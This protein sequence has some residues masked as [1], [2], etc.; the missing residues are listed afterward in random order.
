MLVVSE[1]G[2]D[3][4]FLL[5]L[6]GSMAGSSACWKV[7][8]KFVL[9]WACHVGKE[10]GQEGAAVIASLHFCSANPLS[11]SRVAGGHLQLEVVMP[12]ALCLDAG[13]I[14]GAGGAC[15]LHLWD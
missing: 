1:C 15:G 7:V 4:R 2:P 9:W 8:L 12:V 10:F 3:E 11:P 5:R 13:N 14:A 6:L